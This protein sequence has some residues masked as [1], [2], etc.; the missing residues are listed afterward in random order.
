MKPTDTLLEDIQSTDEFDDYASEIAGHFQDS[1]YKDERLPDIRDSF[2]EALTDEGVT[3]ER[4]EVL[5]DRLIKALIQEAKGRANIGSSSDSSSKVGGGPLPHS[6]YSALPGPLYVLLKQ[7]EEEQINMLRSARHEL[8]DHDSDTMG[9]LRGS[10]MRRPS[11]PSEA[12]ECVG[13]LITAHLQSER[14]DYGAAIV[15]NCPS[16]GLQDIL[17]TIAPQDAGPDPDVLPPHLRVEYDTYV[18]L[19]EDG[20]LGAKDF[21]TR[22]SRLFD[23]WDCED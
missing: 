22:V 17:A 11:T 18:K 5:A 8:L 1:D 15:E 3:G 12:Q 13:A 9:L 14:L 4:V 20:I 10:L 6:A 23:K 2:R 19:R 7:I 21:H 16:L